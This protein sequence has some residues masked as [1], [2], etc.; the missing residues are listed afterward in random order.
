MEPFLSWSEEAKTRFP[1]LV[2][3]TG[4]IRDVRVERQTRET[5]MLKE[6]IITKMRQNYKAELLKDDST[7]RAYRDLYWSLGIDPT[8]TR[9]SGEALL[10][11]VLHG[12]DIP[13]ISDVVD[14][15]NLAS[16][17]TIIPLSGFDQDLIFPPLEIRFS[18]EK[19]EFKCIGMSKLIKLTEKMLLVADRKQIL[20][21]YPYRDA[22]ATR[23]TEKTHN[24]L[25]VGYGAPN[26]SIT[27]LVAVVEKALDYIEKAAGGRKET[28]NVFQ[29]NQQH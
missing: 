3:C 21:I 6:T 18:N 17:E 29:S 22:H 19:D 5:A 13:R 11:R 2:V 1:N 14:A 27:Q 20:C 25:I 8:K 10:R 28:V 7:V 16:L 23:I 4:S 24:V 15:Y 26:I 12:N 9:P